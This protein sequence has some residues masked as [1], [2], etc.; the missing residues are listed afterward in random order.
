[1]KLV[2]LSFVS[3]L[4]LGACATTSTPT[5][6]ETFQ[7]ADKDGDGKVSRAEAA[8]HIVGEAFALYD[9]NGDGFVDAQ[10]FTQGGGT[11]EAFRKINRSGSGRMTL[12]EARANPEVLE[13]FLVS[14]DEADAD[15]DGFVTPAEMEAYRVRLQAAVR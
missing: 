4:F 2:V 12:Q 11:L 13:R 6:A 7:R 14:F 1:M 8:D 15:A 9:K 10:E 5:A 3:V